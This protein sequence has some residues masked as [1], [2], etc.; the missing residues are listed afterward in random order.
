[1][2]QFLDRYGNTVELSFLQNVFEEKA[3]HVFVICQYQDA[4]LLT[5][6]KIRGLEFPGGKTE[7]GET[8]EDAARREVFEETGATI[9]EIKQIAQYRVH[10]ENGSFVKA[11]FWGKIKNINDT[12]N[13]YETEGP[14]MIQDDLLQVRFGKE[15]SFIMKDQVVEECIKYIKNE[16]E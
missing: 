6:H 13:Y 16:K 10:G 1:M 3:K 7:E 4:W 8:L 2:K 15:Y 9:N 5:K 14:V 11:V 12:N